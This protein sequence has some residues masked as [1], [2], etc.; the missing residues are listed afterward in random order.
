MDVLDRVSVFDHNDSDMA[1][2][3]REYCKAAGWT[4]IC[5]DG[6]TQIFYT[7]SDNEIISIHTD[8]EEKF[9]VVYKSSMKN[10]YV[11]MILMILFII[12]MYMQLTDNTE[13]LAT[14]IGILSQAR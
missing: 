10:I 14:N 4:Y 6:G 1:L 11:Q 5:E 2:E 13:V 12:S 3:Y 8:E 7:D 9:K